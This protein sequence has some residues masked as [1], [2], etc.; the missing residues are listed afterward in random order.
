MM[1]DNEYLWKKCNQKCSTWN[2]PEDRRCYQCHKYGNPPSDE[3]EKKSGRGRRSASSS[4]KNNHEGEDHDSDCD[5]FGR[6]KSKKS[7][8]DEWPP[9]F[10]DGGDDFKLDSRSGMFYDARSDFF[11]DPTSKLY[12]GNK[13]HAY[14][15]YDAAKDRFLPVESAPSGEQDSETNPAP[16]PVSMSATAYAM[17]QDHMMLVPEA[18]KSKIIEPPKKVIA[19]NLKTPAVS[20]KSL[21]KKRKKRSESTS[22]GDTV[23]SSGA[24]ETAV[25]TAPVDGVAKPA[26]KVQKHYVAN[27]EKWAEQQKEEKASPAT[28]APVP[29]AKAPAVTAKGKPICWV[30]K[31]KFPTM[32][33]L[34]Q[35][36]EQSALHKENLAKQ[37]QEQ[38]EKDKEAQDEAA[39]KAKVAEETNKYVD[40]AKQRRNMYG[41]DLVLP[42]VATATTAADAME[43]PEFDSAVATARLDNIHD[44]TDAN[45]ANA[46][47]GH[48][49]L[50]KLGWKSGSSL[51]RGTEQQQEQQ[52]A[53]AKDWNRIEN[54]AAQNQSMSRRYPS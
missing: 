21:E 17:E 33:K 12:Y 23:K 45:T 25:A 54:L 10:H 27:I 3:D 20:K 13:K 18:S 16:P 26:N 9:C 38:A 47:I 14:F 7:K 6:R 52:A 35:H 39:A 19:I 22:E 11:Y 40:R 15:S 43:A 31:R 50:S 53:L 1:T 5:D 51:G 4:P 36:N 49:M 44:D 2:Y 46:N 30:C 34:Q 48:Q 28:S 41:P 42:P 8:R 37:Q 29:G 24:T 32:E